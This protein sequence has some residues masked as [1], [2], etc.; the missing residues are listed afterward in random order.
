MLYKNRDHRKDFDTAF[1]LKDGK[2][3]H[4]SEVP[5]EDNGLKCGC[6]C[7]VCNDM[8]VAKKKGKKLAPYFAHKSNS[9]CTGSVE[10]A[11][12]L[13]A[14]EIIKENRCLVLPK[15]SIW[16]GIVDTW[17]KENHII[18]TDKI[19]SYESYNEHFFIDEDE[20]RVTIDENDIEY[21][22]EN[23]VVKEQLIYF[24]N[25]T[26]EK[27]ID[28]IRPDIVLYKKDRELLVEIRVTHE[29]DKDKLD[30]IKS[31][32]KPTIEIDLSLYNIDYINFNREEVSSLILYESENKTWIYHN[33]A[34][35]FKKKIKK[36]LKLRLENEIKIKEKR[37]KLLAYKKEQEMIKLKE[38][39]KSYLSDENLHKRELTFNKSILNEPIWNSLCKYIDLD[40]D[41][42]PDYLNCKID[43]DTAIF[44]CNRRVCQTKIFTS[45]IWNWQKR[46]LHRFFKISYVINWI[47]NSKDTDN[48]I[49]N[50]VNWEYV[51]NLKRCKENLICT[52]HPDLAYVLKAFFVNLLDYDFVEFTEINPYKNIHPYHC[53]F[54]KKNQYLNENR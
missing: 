8:L 35:L 47:K 5:I 26:L 25:V 41:T 16:Y 9:S 21:L 14:K 44:N 39:M 12:H 11:L 18:I 36:E 49:Y 17:K 37:E 27:Q 43:G 29:I 6:F 34:E 2:I 48:S 32:K 22:K 53:S 51:W 19:Y 20:G 30:K 24:D 52:K 7:P 50:M 54:Y 46:G 28:N 40:I 1:G 33:E 38:Y 31:I 42:L 13:F 10:T 15:L 23:A 3:I 4:I 45:F